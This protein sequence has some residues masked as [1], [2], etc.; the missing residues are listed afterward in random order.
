MTTMTAPATRR[1]GLPTW[2]RVGGWQLTGHWFL[3]GGY[4]LTAIAATA[5]TIF[6]A[7]RAST[8]SMS[9]ITIAQQGA[10]WFAF[11][12]AIYFKTN[13]LGPMVSAGMTRRAIEKSTLL[14]AGALGATGALAW[15][16]V[17]HAEHWLFQRNGWT[18]GVDVGRN[19]VADT[20]DLTFFAG[21][22]L[23]IAVATVCGS[24]VG[25]SYVRWGPAATLALPLTVLPL[26]LCALFGVDPAT[27]FPPFVGDL[28]GRLL[29]GDWE[30]SLATRVAIGLVI[31]AATVLAHHLLIRRVPIRGA[32]A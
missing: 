22:A 3:F 7:T 16:L 30:P 6:L 9:V 15:L 1:P 21:L 17:G 11:G 28:G 4:L 5:L 2:A 23:I 29:G 32:K 27:I 13:W 14:A 19:S 31:L 12:V 25:L 26:I 8:P 20:P 24:I 18:Y 10:I